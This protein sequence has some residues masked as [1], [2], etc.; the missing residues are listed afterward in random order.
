MNLGSA[1]KKMRTLKPDNPV[2]SVVDD[3]A[4]AS[5][6]RIRR[7]IDDRKAIP[8]TLADEIKKAL[9]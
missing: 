9:G 5:K 2:D 6:D 3:M 8:N 1:V 4:I 7:E